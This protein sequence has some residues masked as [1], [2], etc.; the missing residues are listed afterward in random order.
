MFV[1]LGLAML[2]L[3]S[4]EDNDKVAV[5]YINEV[6][7]YSFTPATVSGYGGT[8]TIA[9]TTNYTWK[10]SGYTYLE[11]CS[12]DKIAGDAG[13]GEIVVTVAP[14]TSGSEAERSESFK[15]LAGAATQTV[16]ITQSEEDQLIV[17]QTS[18]TIGAEGGT[19]QVPVK[20]NIDYS[21]FI[22]TD[23]TWL[24]C[25]GTKAV[26]S[27]VVTLSVAEN[28]SSEARSGT[29]TISGGEYAYVVTVEQEGVPEPEPEGATFNE[30]WTK[31]F[32]SDLTSISDG[33][34]FRLGVQG[35]NLLMANSSEIY[36]VTAS[37]GEYVSSFGWASISSVTPNS[38]VT[39]SVGNIL[40]A[41]NAT[42]G[43]SSEEVF[44]IYKYDGSNM[45]ELISYDANNFTG[46]IM[47]NVRVMG[48]VDGD[49]V[50]VAIVSSVTYYVA[51]QITGG[52]VGEPVSGLI[53]HSNTG[54]GN[55]YNGCV[56]PIS[57]TL[58]DGLV[59][60]GY[61]GDRRLKYCADPVDAK[62]W[63]SG[64]D[65]GATSNENYGCLSVADHNGKKYCAIGQGGHFSYS[66]APT[67]VLLD[68]TDLDNIETLYSN[69]FT[70]SFSHV[71]GDDIMLV[72]DGSNLTM[73]YADRG[74][75]FANCGT[76]DLPK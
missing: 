10:V 51:W 22:P 70:G 76:F 42:C 68:I 8:V 33:Y 7:G 3:V 14:N 50:V 27:Y 64:Y 73:Y 32:S 72:S 16:T 24:T 47:G 49:A 74:Y 18:F 59:Y 57:S 12:V 31:N 60:I 56:C 69:R 45:T 40:V 65:L 67:A 39:D 9:F 6:D 38:M 66:L 1:I 61:D 75:N 36:T 44:K 15:I 52:V 11:W 41:A 30:T 4:C 63:T 58:T 54:L 17:E 35:N 19:V 26:E 37:T 13:R 55:T 46:G 71:G 21:V 43:E 23:V 29:A 5:A 28:E 48:D 34:P 53:A 20:A 25:I 2:A 62:S